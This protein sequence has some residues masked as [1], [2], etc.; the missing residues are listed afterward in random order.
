MKK[1]T[2]TFLFTTLLTLTSCSNTHE[3]SDTK[4]EQYTITFDTDGG[5]Y[6]SPKKVTEG[7]TIKKLDVPTKD[8]YT[9]DYW[10]YEG[11]EW[12]FSTKVYED[13]TLLA[14][15][16]EK[17]YVISINNEGGEYFNVAGEGEYYTGDTCTLTIDDTLDYWTV[18][19]GWYYNNTLLSEER[20]YTFKVEKDMQITA[21]K[22]ICNAL[23][24]F[25]HYNSKGQLEWEESKEKSGYPAY[26]YEYQYDDQG[27]ISFAMKYNSGLA[28]Y[29]KVTYTYDTNS[30]TETYIAND[31]VYFG[32]TEHFSHEMYYQFNEYGD[33]VRQVK[34]VEGHIGYD[35][36]DGTNYTYEYKNGKKVK[37]D[38]TRDDG[39]RTTHEVFTYNEDGTL[40]TYYEKIWTQWNDSTTETTEVYHYENGLLK[41]ISSENYINTYFYNE[42][43]QLIR[44]VGKNTYNAT[45]TYTNSWYFY[46]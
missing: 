45:P 26:K 29:Y 12:D 34:A 15:W 1:T 10:S 39:T 41:N 33:L 9:F 4:L 31:N 22:G 5:S 13:M 43:N 11:E 40:A 16:K 2:T 14:I 19:G 6:L 21:K 18:F 32:G 42:S 24:N 46:N 30:R 17:P 38:S 7:N 28:S 20:T 27:R 44:I 37:C 25:Y 35:F 3:I 23:A 8:G 36:V